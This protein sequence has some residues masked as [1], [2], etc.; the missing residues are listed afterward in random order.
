MSIRVIVYVLSALAGVVVVLTRL[1]MGKDE[2]AG[3]VRISRFVINAH[4]ILGVLGLAAWTTYLVTNDSTDLGI[5]RDLLGILALGALWATAFLGLLILV[6]W[7]PI[8]G[9]HASATTEDS[10]STGPGLSVLAHVGL[11]VGVAVFT[12]TYALQMV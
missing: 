9:R 4:T 1:R 5:T 10:W 12:A 3:R 2:A 11:V 8:R 6:R 7:L